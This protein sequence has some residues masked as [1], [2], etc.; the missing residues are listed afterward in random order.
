MRETKESQRKIYKLIN[1][2]E[3]SKNFT[4]KGHKN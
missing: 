3:I 4:F 1:H 2:L